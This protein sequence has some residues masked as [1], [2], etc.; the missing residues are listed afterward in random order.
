MVIRE[1]EF[2][3]WKEEMMAKKKKKIKKK[4]SKAKKKISKKKRFY[5]VGNAKNFAFKLFKHKN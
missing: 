1:D 4:K 2:Y 5:V 3:Q